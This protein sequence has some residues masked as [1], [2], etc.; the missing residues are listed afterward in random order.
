MPTVLVVEDERVLR[1]TFEQFLH[2]EGY[3]VATAENYD[4][5]LQHIETQD[6]DVIVTD[7]ILEGRTGVDLLR[8]VKRLNLSSEV[9]MVTGEP[10]VETA[11]EA[12]RLGAFDYLPKPVT[13]RDLLRVVRLALE[14]KKLSEE[15]DLYAKRVDMFRRE[16]EAVFNSVKEGIVTVDTEMRIQQLN[17]ATREILGLRGASV[18]GQELEAAFPADMAAARTALIET[19]SSR[20]AVPEFRLESRG[21]HGR[22]RV[23][24]CSTTPLLPDGG[25]EGGAVLLIRDVTRLTVLERQVEDHH[26]YHNMIGRSP[27]MQEIFG[28]IRNLAETDSTVLIEGESGTGK[29]LVASALH[30]ASNRSGGPFI[31]VNCAALSEDILESELFGHVKG[32]FTG[33]LRDRVGRF[34]AADGGT[35][36]LDEIG[37]ISPRLQL[38]LLRVL[39]EREFERVGDSIPI[40]TDVRV[41]ASTTQD[42]VTKIQVGEFREDLYYRLN[43]VRID[44]PP[45]RERRE[46]IPLLVDH[47]CRRFNGAFKKEIM[48]VAP[49]SMD[50]FMKYPWWG[51]I[52]EMEN[53]LERAF[54]VCHDTVILPRH[55]PPEVLNYESARRPADLS[56]QSTQLSGRNQN[57]ERERVLDVLTQTDWNVAKTARI[58]GVARNT[59]YQKIKGYNLRR[60]L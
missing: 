3:E 27:R 1:L 10:N 33:A 20:E 55:L 15:R 45:L 46:D 26:Q 19:L 54:I 34:E 16:L 50:I 48:G 2:T 57:V 5:A 37:D 47:L 11:S 42:L 18:I 12:V 52:R 35:I 32:A 56:Q 28:L 49:E 58:L 7:I 36:L 40:R 51:N 29:E 41:I 23:L 14:R 53:C 21:H 30:Y 8:T 43:V 13:G 60:P 25:I 59:L 38:R 39:Q 17:Q 24:V 22:H 44:I 4:K 9:I 31:K 6:F